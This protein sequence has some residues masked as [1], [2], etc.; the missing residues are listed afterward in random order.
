[1]PGAVDTMAGLRGRGLKLA[2]AT[3]SRKEFMDATVKRFGLM[4]YLDAAVSGSE[5]RANKP[6]PD[7]Y[8]EAAGKLGLEPRACVAFEDSRGGVESAKAAGM[9]CVAVPNRYTAGMDLSPADLRIPDLTRGVWAMEE[10]S[11]RG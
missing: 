6:E 7:V 5:V 10:L 3:G 11:R 1:M 2:L 8:L 4:E 9:L